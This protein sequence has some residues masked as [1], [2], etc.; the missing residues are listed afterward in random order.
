MYHHDIVKLD[1]QDNSATYCIFCLTN[2]QNCYD[3]EDSQRLF[4]YFFIM[5]KIKNQF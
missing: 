4:I 3:I 1:H 2:L 5:N